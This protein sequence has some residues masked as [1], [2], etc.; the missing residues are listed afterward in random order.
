MKRVPKIIWILWYQ[1][2]DEAPQ[3]VKACLKSWESKNPNWVINRLDQF[4]I[5][6]FIDINEILPNYDLREISL[7]SLSDL[8]RISLLNK[9]GG[10]WADATLMCRIS[11]DSWLDQMNN[12]DF[13]A[14]SKPSSDRLI[15]SWFLAATKESY[16]VAKWNQSAKNFWLNRKKTDEYFW[17]HYLFNSL[18]EN[19]SDF[20]TCWDSSF[21]LSAKKPHF[22]LPYERIFDKLTEERVKEIEQIDTPVFKL[23]HKYDQARPIEGTLLEYLLAA[24]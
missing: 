3:V 22:F 9:F 18:Y 6:D 19:D 20:Q 5:K 4:N 2:W 12:A 15:S 13:F 1:G 14:F 17:F 23:T 21:K 11:L 16:I 8:I 10:V 7:A 24:E